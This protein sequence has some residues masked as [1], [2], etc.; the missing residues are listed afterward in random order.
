MF[1]IVTANDNKHNYSRSFKRY[2]KTRATRSLQAIF[3]TKR[4]DVGFF[5]MEFYPLIRDIFMVRHPYLTI[6][7]FEA[8]LQLHANQ[9]FSIED[10]YSCTLT[11][12]FAKDDWDNKTSFGFRTQKKFL[13]KCFKHGLFQVFRNQSPYNKK[14]YEFS[15]YARTEFKRVYENILCLSKIRYEDPLFV[16]PKIKKSTAHYKKI[17]KQNA[18]CDKFKQEASREFR[19]TDRQFAAKLSEV[20][21]EARGI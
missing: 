15:P 8:L 16:P 19:T 9:P 12:D 20:R 21:A 14:L 11:H 1:E 2:L 4:L 6:K 10:I 3:R 18:Y 7:D 5:W 17:L 13:H